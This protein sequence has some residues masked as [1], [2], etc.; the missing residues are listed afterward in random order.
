[1]STFLY[2]WLAGSPRGP[3]EPC[4]GRAVGTRWAETSGLTVILFGWMRGLMRGR[5]CS[6]GEN[7]LVDVFER[8]SICVC[9]FSQRRCNS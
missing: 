7:L 8:V 2:C 1:M 4:S 9:G 5:W 3:A 6:N